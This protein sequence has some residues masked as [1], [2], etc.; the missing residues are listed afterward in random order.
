M[1]ISACSPPAEP[2]WR[3]VST[4]P[5]ACVRN[6]SRSVTRSTW[7]Y[8][9]TVWKPS[10]T[11]R[12][13]VLAMAAPFVGA[14]SARRASSAP[15]RSRNASLGN[16]RRSLATSSRSSSDAASPAATSAPTRTASTRSSNRSA[17]S[18][19]GMVSFQSL[20][21]VLESAELQLL[22]GAFALS[23]RAGDLRHAPLLGEA[24]MDDAPLVLGQVADR[25]VQE[26]PA[27]RSL[28]RGALGAGVAS[29]RRRAVAS[30][31]RVVVGDRVP[32]DAV[33]PGDEGDAA[34][35]EAWKVGQRLLEDLAG[36]VLGVGSSGHPV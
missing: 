15:S 7:R 4:A 14:P 2:G 34:P 6:A 31:A 21:E 36:Q 24:Q 28:G 5:N 13:E 29:G 35:L 11:G 32:G 8:G 10:R 26:R 12:T 27:L 18:R 33:E 30:D 1:L 22:D 9:V 23:E 16:P 20:P 3:S 25:A 19:S 17:G